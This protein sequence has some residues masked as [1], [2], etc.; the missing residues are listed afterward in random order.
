MWY[1]NF[2]APH[3]VII[4]KMLSEC[5]GGI[6]EHVGEVASK[7]AMKTLTPG[8]SCHPC[9]FSMKKQLATSDMY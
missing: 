9:G 8:G 1:R 6:G 5:A 3:G 7:S 2:V 4:M